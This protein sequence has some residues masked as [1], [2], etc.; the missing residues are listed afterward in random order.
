[1][2]LDARADDRETRGFISITTMSPAN[3]NIGHKNTEAVTIR[4]SNPT[5][6]T[7]YLAACKGFHNTMATPKQ[8]ILQR[9]QHMCFKAHVA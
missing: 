8:A 3:A 2:A 6:Y 1:V 7:A 9:G 5:R 4:E